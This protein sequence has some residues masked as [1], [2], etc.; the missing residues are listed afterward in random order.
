MES[1]VIDALATFSDCPLE[2]MQDGYAGEDVAVYEDLSTAIST[3]QDLFKDTSLLYK[4]WSRLNVPVEPIT[5]ITHRGRQALQAHEQKV[6]GP[7]MV[8]ILD[9][10]ERSDPD[11]WQAPITSP[12]RR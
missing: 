12:N 5:S 9:V 10:M 7:K 1:T 2:P 3:L 4:Y 6:M 11:Y 8:K